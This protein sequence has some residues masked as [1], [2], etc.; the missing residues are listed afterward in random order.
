MTV[1]FAADWPIAE[2]DSMIDDHNANAASDMP[3]GP[4]RP[5]ENNVVSIN[6]DISVLFRVLEHRMV[7][8]R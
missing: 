1:C 7:F 5:L 3:T 8:N 6:F 2:L 4:L